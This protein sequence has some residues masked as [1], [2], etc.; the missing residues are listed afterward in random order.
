MMFFLDCGMPAALA[1][2]DGG[3]VV[4]FVASLSTLRR[5]ALF[6]KSIFGMTVMR[7]THIDQV[8]S[9]P[10]HSKRVAELTNPP[11]SR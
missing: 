10:N 7:E 4:V 6:V 9:E 3:T 8:A 5:D 2:R 1:G 11:I